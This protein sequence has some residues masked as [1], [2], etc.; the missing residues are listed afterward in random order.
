MTVREYIAEYAEGNNDSINWLKQ[1]IPD[2]DW[3]EYFRR[4]KTSANGAMDQHHWGGRAEQTLISKF[5]NRP[6]FV[7]YPENGRKCARL[8]LSSDQSYFGQTTYDITNNSFDDLFEFHEET[9]VVNY[10]NGNHYQAIVK[11]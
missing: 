11:G 4:T 8:H 7:V 3:I 6:I 2:R 10:V 9:I 5:L 1:H